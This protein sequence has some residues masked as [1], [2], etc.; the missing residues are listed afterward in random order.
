[1]VASSIKLGIATL[2]TLSIGSIVQNEHKNVFSEARSTPPTS[3]FTFP[4]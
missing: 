1:M 2:A 3:T 4:K